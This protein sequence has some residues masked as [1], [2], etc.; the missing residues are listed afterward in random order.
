MVEPTIKAKL[1]LEPVGGAGAAGA[2]GAAG[3]VGETATQASKRSRADDAMIRFLPGIFGKLGSIGKF[4]GVG[5]GLTFAAALVGAITGQIAA[6][7][8]QTPSQV[9]GGM[10]FGGL[11]GGNK[12]LINKWMGVGQE[13]Y[14][15]GRGGEEVLGG[16]K[17]TNPE[18]QK[19]NDLLKETGV[20]FDDASGTTL[21]LNLQMAALMDTSDSAETGLKSLTETLAELTVEAPKV[22]I[23][24]GEI[25][26]GMRGIGGGRAAQRTSS[27]M[28]SHERAYAAEV[29]GKADRSG[30][31]VGGFLK[32]IPSHQVPPSFLEKNKTG[33]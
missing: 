28:T 24:I 2:G 4:F 13:N 31:D 29:K 8:G 33:G 32:N 25:V 7:S 21:L 19:A 11:T 1:I 17:Q 16:L 9:A 30:F 22:S 27:R 5:T 10:G 20:I 14:I 12:D 3:A 26:N 23:A 18:V 15:T 6:Q